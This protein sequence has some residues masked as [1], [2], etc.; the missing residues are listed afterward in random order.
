M[1]TLIPFI[2]AN[3]WSVSEVIARGDRDAL[4]RFWLTA[5]EDLFESLWVSPMGEATKALV[6][7]LHQEFPFTEDQR[8]V[9]DRINQQLQQGLD[10]PGTAQLLIAVFLVSPPGQLR[11]ANA[12]RW[13]PS[14][15]MPAYADLYESSDS[16]GLGL[17]QDEAASASSSPVPKVDFGEFPRTLDEL[18]GNR[19]QLNRMLGLANLYYIDPEDQEIMRELLQLRREFAA[20]IDSCAEQALQQLFSTDLGDRYWAVV[21]SGIQK[22]PMSADDQDFKNRA[23]QRLSPSEG[24]GFQSPGA[25]NAF[26]I[27]MLFY[28]PGTMKVDEPEKKLPHWLL[29]GYQDVFARSLSTTD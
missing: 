8:S 26:L 6:K 14:W 11:I 12:E 28:L 2:P 5:P 4:I 13:L 1:T 10:R 21:R 3:P 9:R 27:A 29:Q 7:Q 19:I 25:T 22:E 24:G 23:V 20:A 18:I 17:T 16:S 15:L